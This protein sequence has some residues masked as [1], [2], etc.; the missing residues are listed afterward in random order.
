MDENVHGVNYARN[1]AGGQR[2]GA[3]ELSPLPVLLDGG[4]GPSLAAGE[5]HW[6]RQRRLRRRAWRR[7]LHRQRG[8]WADVASCSRRCHH[9][10]CRSLSSSCGPM[11]ATLRWR[12]PSPPSR[13]RRR[14]SPLT[15]HA[16]R[17]LLPTRRT[18]GKR[19]LLAPP[20]SPLLPLHLLCWWLALHPTTLPS[21]WSQCVTPSPLP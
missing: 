1:Y 21:L 18:C 5:P 17:W 13:R 6:R 16:A 19:S 9:H 3:R 2:R 10:C 4:R 8:R 15:L 12:L 20:P 7:L 14:R 11:C